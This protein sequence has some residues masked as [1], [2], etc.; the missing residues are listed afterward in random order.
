MK[1]LTEM[2]M[3][4]SSLNGVRKGLVQ[5]QK[6]FCSGFRKPVNKDTIAAFKNS[7]VTALSFQEN[8]QKIVRFFVE[9]VVN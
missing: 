6:S 7:F 9:A 1:T 2:P 3:S 8:Q 4:F 5:S